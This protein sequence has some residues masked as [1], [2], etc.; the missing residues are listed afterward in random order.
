VAR[1]VLEHLGGL[2]IG[3]AIVPVVVCA[4][5]RIWTRYEAR[6]ATQLER[7]L[8]SERAILLIAGRGRSL[9]HNEYGNH[10]CARGTPRVRAAHPSEFDKQQIIK[11]ARDGTRVR[12]FGWTM[13]DHDHPDDAE[14]D[15]TGRAG[16]RGT[17]LELHP[18]MRIVP[19]KRQGQPPN[20]TLEAQAPSCGN[21]SGLQ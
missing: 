14:P 3:D 4:A 16:S 12:V 5:A 6:A 10:S 2:K 19:V 7:C 1:L 9:V 21:C 20:R 11:W 18:V 8:K 17:I 13:L 15:K